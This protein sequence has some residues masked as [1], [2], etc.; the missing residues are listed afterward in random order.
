LSGTT[1][2]RPKKSWR[3]AVNR[4]DFDIF[5]ANLI[6]ISERADFV[7]F[8][9]CTAEISPQKGF[10]SLA[11]AWSL[12]NSTHQMASSTPP[13]PAIP[14]EELLQALQ[15]HYFSERVARALQ[16]EPDF[17]GLLYRAHQICFVAHFARETLGQELSVNQLARAFGCHLNR[18]KAALANGF[19]EA[20]TR[21]RHM[22]FDG[23]SEAD[24]LTWIEAEA[25]KSKPVTRTELRHYCKA[26][27]TRSVSKRWV[28]SFILCHEADLTDRK[29]TP[30]E[31]VRLE[32]PVS[33]WTRP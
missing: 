24:I 2:R 6:F 23:N 1:Y 5:I 8:Q 33:S 26:K 4:E 9:S 21:G 3:I 10:V 22:V 18:I 14:H 31:E 12:K 15:Q 32:V 30:Q 17:E 28:D 7:R 19:E 29:S 11:T 20:K 13:A 16:R 25:K 27:Y